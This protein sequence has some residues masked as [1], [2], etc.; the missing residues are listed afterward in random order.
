M[1]ESSAMRNRHVVFIFVFV[2]DLLLALFDY[3]VFYLSLKDLICERRVVP[4]TWN[5]V[6][7]A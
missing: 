7:K 6:P 4:E 3:F 2:F 1:I 5:K